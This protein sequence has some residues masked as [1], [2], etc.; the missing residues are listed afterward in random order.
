MKSWKSVGNEGICAYVLRFFINGLWGMGVIRI[1][2]GSWRV[3]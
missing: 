2:E 3:T 1:L